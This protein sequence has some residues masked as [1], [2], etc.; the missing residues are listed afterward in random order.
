VQETLSAHR[1]F[2]TAAHAYPLP[3]F[4]GAT[5]EVLLGNLLRKKL[6][7]GPDEWVSKYGAGT[8]KN[9]VNGVNGLDAKQYVE[10]WNSAAQS[11]A[12]F[13]DELKESDAWDSNFTMAEQEAGVE[14]VVTGLRRKLYDD[15]D[16][17]EGEGD[18]DESMEDVMATATAKDKDIDTSLRPMQMETLLRFMSTGAQPPQR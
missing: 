3:T 4:P 16:D 12:E 14:K 15:D 1:A 11:N 5:Q 8:L 17:E 2:L 9:E 13:V 6:E 10:L 7:V 18:G